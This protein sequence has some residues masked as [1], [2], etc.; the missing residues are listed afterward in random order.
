MLVLPTGPKENLMRFLIARQIG[1]LF[2][3]CLLAMDAG[4]T[5][6]VSIK[7]AVKDS[8]KSDFASS[9][10]ERLLNAQCLMQAGPPSQIGMDGPT[11]EQEAAV[12]P[13]QVFRMLLLPLERVKQNPKWHPEGDVLGPIQGVDLHGR[14]PARPHVQRQPLHQLHRHERLVALGT[15]LEHVDDV[16]VRELLA[17]APF[18]EEALEDGRLGEEL[19]ARAISSLGHG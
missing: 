1:A 17:G 9:T 5:A 2:A 12:D 8:A 6:T 10:I 13:H 14:A 16:R 3:A 15:H 11:P 4:A 18:V 19:L 7:V